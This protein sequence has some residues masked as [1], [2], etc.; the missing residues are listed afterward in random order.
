MSSF[1]NWKFIERMVVVLLWLKI[2]NKLEF[3]IVNILF[4]ETIFCPSSNVVTRYFFPVLDISGWKS[5]ML[6]I[7][8]CY[9]SRWQLTRASHKY[10]IKRKLKTNFIIL[11]F[12][13]LISYYDLQSHI[14]NIY[15]YILNYEKIL[16]ILLFPKLF[17]Y[18]EYNVKNV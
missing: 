14:Q 18:V 1:S 17:L 6:Q 13:V 15:L 11:Q 7:L 2:Q 5:T 4:D 3:N 8:F 10:S 16:A 9:N 12:F